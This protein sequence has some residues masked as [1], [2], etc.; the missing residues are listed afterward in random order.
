[1]NICYPL[2][3]TRCHY[4]NILQW[5]CILILLIKRCKELAQNIIYY[6]LQIACLLCINL[7]EPGQGTQKVVLTTATGSPDQSSVQATQGLQR[8]HK[9]LTEEHQGRRVFSLGW[10]EPHSVQAHSSPS[11]L[12]PLVVSQHRMCAMSFSSHNHLP[13][14]I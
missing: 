3:C 10:P 7:P 8:K 1:M 9:G 11:S 6:G 4:P 5:E 14:R 12:T 2:P 13:M